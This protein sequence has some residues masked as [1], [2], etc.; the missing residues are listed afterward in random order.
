VK[1]NLGDKRE[2]ILFDREARRK[3]AFIRDRDYEIVRR[4][5]SE[6]RGKH[7][8][9]LRIISSYTTSSASAGKKKMKKTKPSNLRE[10]PVGG[11]LVDPTITLR[12]TATKVNKR[13]IDRERNWHDKRHD[14]KKRYVSLHA[15]LHYVHIIHT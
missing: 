4:S 1:K 14:I 9:D 11:Y 12:E 13:E 8:I 15:R 5:H 3:F 7:K 6:K 10:I 2:K